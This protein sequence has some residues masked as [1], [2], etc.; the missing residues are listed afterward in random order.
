MAEIRCLLDG[1]PVVID[2]E[3]T[4]RLL[5]ILRDSFKKIAVKEGCG[6][7]E[8]GACSILL[9]GRLV[10]SCIR[11]VGRIH[12]FSIDTL[13]GL[14][15]TP[16]GAC[17]IEAFSETGA[18]QCGFCTP[19]MVLATIALLRQDQDPTPEEIRVALSGN[20][21]RCTGY[22]LIVQG[23]TL[24]AKRGRERHIWN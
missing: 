11:P 4:R 17:V 10:N 23:V 14:R 3:P 6:E 16:E 9:D 18:V 12:G 2:T 22:D 19:G 21:C 8:C 15:E 13:D 7:G 1:Q 24:A 5:D 20:L